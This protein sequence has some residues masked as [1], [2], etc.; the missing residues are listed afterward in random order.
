MAKKA[1][2]ETIIG[3]KKGGYLVNDYTE[4]WLVYVHLHPTHDVFDEETYWKVF[5]TSND[6][7]LWA[8]TQEGHP[9]LKEI[10][11]TRLYK[12]YR[13]ESEQDKQEREMENKKCKRKT[14]KSKSP[15]LAQ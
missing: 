14:T 1:T 4:K 9:R 3:Q 12:F 13:L 5:S 6:A 8:A 15:I 11:P 7:D 2:T 10:E